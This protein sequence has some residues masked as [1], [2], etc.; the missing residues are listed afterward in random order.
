MSVKF[1]APIWMQMKCRFTIQKTERQVP[2]K[3]E[4]AKNGLIPFKDDD[5]PSSLNLKLFTFHKSKRG[6]YLWIYNTSRNLV[7]IQQ[8][9]EQYN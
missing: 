9:L 3:M 1:T 4:K 6:S 5:N 7:N 8:L 2:T